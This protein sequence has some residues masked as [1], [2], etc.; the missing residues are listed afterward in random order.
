M[1]VALFLL[2]EFGICSK[3]ACLMRQCI[4]RLQMMCLVL[5]KEES[6]VKEAEKG[7]FPCLMNH[8][9]HGSICINI[10]SPTKSPT[11]FSSPYLFSTISERT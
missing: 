11:I 10:L 5:K 2:W 4:G 6:I 1:A 3:K 9:R 8:C 7:Q